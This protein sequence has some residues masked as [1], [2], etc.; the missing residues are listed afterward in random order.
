MLDYFGLE[1]HLQPLIDAV[2]VTGGPRSAEMLSTLAWYLRQRDPDRAIA[3]ADEAETVLQDSA[4]ESS[5]RWAG[6]ARLARAYALTMRSQHAE[7]MAQL[8]LARDAFDAA[9]DALGKA[10]CLMVES[11]LARALGEPARPRECLRQAAAAFRDIGDEVRERIAV[12]SAALSTTDSQDVGIDWDEAFE[13]AERLNHAGLL[14]ALSQARSWHHYLQGELA[15]AIGLMIVACEHALASGQMRSAV[16]MMN[17]I[18]SNYAALGSFADA[19]EWG[20]RAISQARRVG[21]P[22]LIGDSMGQT[23]HVLMKLGRHDAAKAL[24]DDALAQ[25]NNDRR[26]VARPV[27][28]IYLG[29]LLNAQGRHE[30]AL[31]QHRE[32]EMLALQLGY[33]THAEAALHGQGKALARLGRRAEAERATRAVFASAAKRGAVADQVAA[34]HALS[35]LAREAGPPESHE[36]LRLL[37]QALDV[38]ATSPDYAVSH[39]VYAALSVEHEAVNDLAAALEYERCA[40]AALH[41]SHSKRAADLALAMQ[42]RYDT[43]RAHA[44]TKAALLH[45]QSLQLDKR[46]LEQETERLARESLVGKAQERERIARDLHDTLLQSVSGLILRFQSVLHRIPPGDK[47]RDL[48]ESALDS[49]ARTLAEGRDCVLDLRRPGADLATGLPQAL[50]SAARELKADYST[51][52]SVVVEGDPRR[53]PLLPAEDIYRIGREALLN[54]FQHARANS[55]ELR[56]SYRARHF[57]LAV[58]DDGCGIAP[59]VLEAGGR[60]GHCGLVGLRERALKIGARL[61]VLSKPQQGTLVE[62]R[63]PGRMAYGKHPGR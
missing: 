30:Q 59:E 57:C 39:E 35:Q 28:L 34:L 62:L 17:N 49:A 1:T 11:L 5:L 4:D 63:V 27:L 54:A 45:V 20:E 29:D 31:E 37:K 19:L 18:S 16:T 50:E 14:A 10:D 55:I 44:E 25:L 42:I 60:S 32:A 23:G 21:R 7:A 53:L 52:F 33:E 40:S 58:Q 46:A 36:P 9:A 8:H 38:A 47:A 22:V 2:S 6:R 43:E 41:A 61:E 13:A 24:L 48:L 51:R 12:A 3:L 26:T 56:L 15:A